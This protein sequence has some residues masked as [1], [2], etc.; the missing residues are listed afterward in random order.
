MPLPPD[1]PGREERALPDLPQNPAK[2]PV[3]LDAYIMQSLGRESQGQKRFF[4]PLITLPKELRLIPSC[5]LSCHFLALCLTYLSSAIF[6]LSMARKRRFLKKLSRPQA[7]SDSGG[8]SSMLPRCNRN[9]RWQRRAND[10]LC[11][12]MREVS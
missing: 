3:Q 8:I 6:L 2:N 7:G 11:V 10:K 9:T 12:A 5:L 1:L 4:K